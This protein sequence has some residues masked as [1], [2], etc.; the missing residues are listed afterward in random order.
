MV[1]IASP[2]GD[3]GR[4]APPTGAVRPAPATPAATTTP[5]PLRAAIPAAVERPAR[6]VRRAALLGLLVGATIAAGVLASAWT[7]YRRALDDEGRELGN[8]AFV[9]ADHTDR[10]FQA[11]EILQSGLAERLATEGLATPDDLL[12]WAG[13]EAAHAILRDRI[14]GV[15]QIEALALLDGGGRLIASSRAWP[16]TRLDFSDREEIRRIMAGEDRVLGLPVRDSRGRW[17]L[18]MASRLRSAGGEPIGVV[19]A[20]LEVGYLERLYAALALAPDGAVSLVR[21]DG[22]LLAR[23][24]PAPSML[25]HA[26]ATLHWP[27]DSGGLARLSSPVDG[28]ERLTATHPVANRGLRVLVGVPMDAALA[29]WRAETLRLGVGSAL[30]L[31]LV[32]A[33]AALTA[34][35]ARMAAE[36][37]AER[38]RHQAELAAQHAL[39]RTAIEGLSQGVWMFGPNGRL[40]LTNGRC[41]GIIGMPAGALRLGATL[42]DL[43]AAATGT[44]G[45]AA[46]VAR[47]AALAATRIAGAFTAELEDGRVVSVVYQPLADSGWIATFE[48]ATARRAAEARLAHMARHDPLTGLPNRLALRERLDTMVEEAA[49]GGG[50]LAVL[51]LDLDRFKAVNEA[52]GHAAGDA[53]LRAAATRIAAS[54]RGGRDGGDVVARVGADEFT[55]A[56]TPAFRVAADPA[57]E[58]AA[59]ARRVVAALSEPFEVEGHRVV[60]GASVGIALYP[61][62]GTQPAV[63]L[64]HADLA[65]GRARSE[66]HGQVRFFEADMDARAQLLRGIENDLRRALAGGGVEFELHYQPVVDVRR[67][68]AVGFEALLRWRHPERGL[69]PPA[70]FV[71]L[72]EEIGLIAPL[73]ALVLRR[74]CLEAAAWPAPLR[75]A[76]NL[77][78][79]QFRDG[80][81][82]DAVQDALRDSGLAPARLELEITEGVLLRRTEETL[83]TLHRLRALGVRVVMDDFGTGYSSLGYLRSFPFD[84]VKVDRAFVREIETRPDDVAIVQAVTSLC[85][86]LGMRVTAEGVETEAQLRVL[87]EEGVPEAQGYLFSRAVPPAE[88]PA[89]LGRLGVAA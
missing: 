3:A 22:T 63:L 44:P 86:R 42:A 65:L 76:V 41:A 28:R 19:L 35:R 18:H 16:V 81:L 7:S 15:P 36:A 84:K 71:G 48:D 50:R 47:L 29:G 82:F 13:R 68:A 60:I 62:D 51:H 79:L 83:S 10:A 26:P 55:I 9:L 52:L 88:V 5:L 72:A 27:A 2:A 69:V 1:H 25:G 17:M 23:D 33:A 73:G 32:A 21:E 45:A 70:E 54:V 39:F 75:V 31:A 74:A 11:V 64:K 4:D 8:L 43:Q 20:G 40:V 6:P 77:S 49:A 80:M 67:R 24:P 14:A 89:V 53:L 37:A 66:G 58:S 38:Q 78:P 59:L 87:A 57:A 46:T 56:L 12:R 30:L 85:L 61:A 34:R